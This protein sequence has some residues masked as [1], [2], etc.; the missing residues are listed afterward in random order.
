MNDTDPTSEPTRAE[1]K[2]ADVRTTT[3][4]GEDV[5]ELARHGDPSHAMKATGQK[6]TGEAPEKAGRGVVWVR[7]SELMSQITAKAAGRG[8]DFHTELAR[9]TRKPAARAVATTRRAISERA[10]RLPPI[11]AF[12]RGHSPAGATRSGI[13]LS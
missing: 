9:R 11:S 1:E 8:I 5:S 3:T 7:P 2:A 10:R 13:G 6:A 4:S 12:G